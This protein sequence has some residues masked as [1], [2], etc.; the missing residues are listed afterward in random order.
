MPACSRLWDSTEFRRSAGGREFLRAFPAIIV[1]D[2]TPEVDACYSLGPYTL[3]QGSVSYRTE[4]GDL[5][6]R[7]K[8][9]N[10]REAAAQL[11]RQ[12]ER[13]VVALPLPT[14]SAA[15][16]I[17][18]APKSD[19]NTPDLVGKWAEDIASNLGL[20]RLASYKSRATDPQKNLSAGESETDLTRRIANSV[21]VS[22]VMARDQ[23]LILDDTIRSG[24]TLR[25]IGRALRAAGAAAVCGLTVAK[26]ARFTQSGIIGFLDREWWQ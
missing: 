12:L 1:V 24:G 22:G 19:A 9:Q 15:S 10:D 3:F 21:G 11:S 20:R 4:W 18:A 5:L 7:A 2:L 23:V 26:D 6:S 17:V 13:C 16:A 25:E 8:Y 14:L